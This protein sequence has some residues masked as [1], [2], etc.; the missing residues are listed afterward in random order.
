MKAVQLAE[1]GNLDSITISN[2]PVPQPR[3]GEVLVQML[4]SP[5][6]PC[7]QLLING[8]FGGELPV[9]LGQEGVGIVTRSGG[10]FTAWR[11]KGKRV[12]VYADG[13][14]AEYVVVP[15]DRVIV[16]PDSIENIPASCAFINPMTAAAMMDLIREGKHHAIVQNAA[17]SSLGKMLVRWCKL[18][19]IVTINF[20]RKEEQIPLLKEMGADYVLNQ[21]DSDLIEK[22]TKLQKTVN[23]TIG[24]DAVGG[25]VSGAVFE[26]L[27]QN[28]IMHVIDYL[29]EEKCNMISPLGLIF[30]NKKIKY[31]LLSTASNIGHNR[32]LTIHTCYP[33]TISHL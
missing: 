13:A 7:D 10:G 32:Q 25:D 29:S 9:T 15:V 18:V 21:N 2:I 6:H 8:E 1:F 17:F 28:G 26:T 12:T 4:Q 27:G 5:I 20:V 23:P 31:R 11:L 22:L 14:W 3:Y 33:E 30:M 19:G 24:F 16:I